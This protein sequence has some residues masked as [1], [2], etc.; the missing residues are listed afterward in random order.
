MRYAV[1]MFDATNDFSRYMARLLILRG[2]ILVFFVLLII[3]ALSQLSQL[4]QQINQPYLF[5][6]FMCALLFS[7]PV[8]WALRNK[9]QIL[10]HQMFFQIVLDIALLSALLFYSGGSTNPLISLLLLP[11]LVA[12]L[13]LS[14][15]QAWSIALLTVLAYTLLMHFYVPLFSVQHEGMISHEFRLHLLGMWL[16]F[17]L[18]IILLISVIV[19]MSEQRRER[20]RQLVDWQQRSIREHAILALGAQAASDAHELGTPI[21][22]LLLLADELSVSNLEQD[23][24]QHVKMIQQQLLHCRHV[25]KRLGQRARISNDGSIEQILVLELTE[26]A[27]AQWINLHPDFHVDLQHNT[28]TNIMG[29]PM[30]EQVIFILLDNAADAGATQVHIELAYHQEHAVI[31]VTDNG[32][33]FIAPVIN[34]LGNEPTTTKTHGKGLGLYLARFIVEQMRGNIYFSNLENGGAL[35]E[36]KWPFP[37]SKEEECE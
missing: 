35:V 29:D 25:L 18:S 23:N 15:R 26:H 32:S 31:R 3:Y 10:G 7:L 6:L 4:S 30:L 11:V 2:I 8:I 20:E 37:A 13:T 34:K 21:N 14:R 33:G 5:G 28:E 16:T 24:H 12:S 27:I 36:L 19:R 22:T 1:R 9:K 17:V